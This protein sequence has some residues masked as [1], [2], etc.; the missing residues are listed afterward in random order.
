MN[1]MKM[2]KQASAMQKKMADAQAALAGQELEFQ[3][4]GGAVTIKISGAGQVLGVRID[5]EVVAGG[6]TDMLE[7]LV[8]TAVQGAQGLAQEA[9]AN[10]MKK[11]TEGMSLPPGMG[12]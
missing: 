1:I 6:D 11:A 8:L 3:A 5:P 12:L 10:E 4:G 7:D 9:A 2:M